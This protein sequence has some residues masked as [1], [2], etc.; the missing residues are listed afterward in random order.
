GVALASDTGPS[1]GVAYRSELRSSVDLRVTV[2]N[3]GALTIPP[4]HVNGIA[5]VD[6]A[7]LAGEFSHA[8]GGW[9]LTAGAT[10]RQ[11]SR[12]SSFK[13]PTIQ[14]PSP[15]DLPGPDAEA[16]NEPDDATGNDAG[17]QSDCV[18]PDAA[19]LR[20]QNTLTPRFAV[21]HALRIHPAAQAALRVGYFYE[22][23]PLPS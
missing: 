10:Y 9:R 8:V 15:A 16:S 13:T 19:Q 14:C 1:F 2:R 18:A 7:Q 6:P 3:L 20:L 22:P 11:W 21:E 4:M 23:S 12:I 17:E 5:Q